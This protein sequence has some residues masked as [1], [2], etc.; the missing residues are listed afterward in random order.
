[1][2]VKAL[3]SFVGAANGQKYRVTEGDEFDLPAGVDWL[4]AGLVV[5]AN[6]PFD[7]PAEPVIKKRGKRDGS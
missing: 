3:K 4:K 2:R 1:M 7:P 6:P 5:E